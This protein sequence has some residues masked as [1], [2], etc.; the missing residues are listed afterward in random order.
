MPVSEIHLTLGYDNETL[1]VD[2]ILR[3]KSENLYR[4]RQRIEPERVIYTLKM[5]KGQHL[6]ENKQLFSLVFHSLEEVTEGKF[7]VEDTSYVVLDNGDKSY[8]PG[9][10]YTID[11]VEVEECTPDTVVPQIELLAPLPNT[12][13]AS[14]D[15]EIR[16]RIS[17]DDAGVDRDKVVVDI[18][19]L[20]YFVT[21]ETVSLDQDV[22]TISPIL[23][24]AY[25]SSVEVNVTVP[26]LQTPLAN[27]AEQNFSFVTSN[28]ML[29]CEQL[30]CFSKSY[31]QLTSKQC[32]QF[33]KLYLQGDD[34]AQRTLERVVD[35]FSL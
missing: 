1:R 30:G 34:V 9:Q 6:L 23:D 17:D 22:L 5:K 14:I 32:V 27:V 16:L 13:G 3:N 11:F 31:H 12:T 29:Q 15:G 18:D 8:L 24:F 21:D 35:D 10:E 25:G 26:D 33:Q 7:W 4:T 19:G 28:D 2:H 20:R